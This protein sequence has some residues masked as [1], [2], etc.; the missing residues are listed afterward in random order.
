MSTTVSTVPWKQFW[1][2]II[3]P[4]LVLIASL[5]ADNIA[6][7]NHGSSLFYGFKYILII[8]ALLPF[9]YFGLRENRSLFF[10]L[11]IGFIF[12]LLYDSLHQALSS[13]IADPIPEIE[14]QF[15]RAVSL[16]LYFLLLGVCLIAKATLVKHTQEREV[17]L[18]EVVDSKR[19][20]ENQ[21][22]ELELMG[23]KSGSELKVISGQKE[24]IESINTNLRN[25]LITKNNLLKHTNEE[26]IK[27]AGELRQFSFMV[28][29]NLR[30]PVAALKGLF[31][32]IN[33]RQNGDND[34]ISK[35]GEVL[36]NL[37]NLMY[38][39]NK[40][41]N[42]RNE[43]Y[44]T[45]EKVDLQDELENIKELLHADIDSFDVQID[46]DFSKQEHVYSVKS[47]VNSILFNLVS[48]GIKY[49][50]KGE[51][52]KIQIWTEKTE[53]FTLL[54]VK[55]YGIG[56][57]TVKNK[58]N[59]FR[60]YSRFNHDVEGRGIGLYLCKMQIESLGGRIDIES[61][62]GEWTEFT[63]KFEN[64][65]A[66]NRQVFFENQSAIM[67]HDED[68]GMNTVSWKDDIVFGSYKE[69]YSH[70]VALQ[71]QHLPKKWVIDCSSQ[72]H[73]PAE[74]HLWMQRNIIPSLD[75]SLKEI[76]LILNDNMDEVLREEM[77]TT[78][79]LLEK[80]DVSVNLFENREDFLSQT[81]SRK[82]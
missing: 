29:H 75:I 53:G 70:L 81:T 79:R 76:H 22:R 10:S 36:V 78:K 27:H 33:E 15:V 7:A 80:Q 58:K 25:K 43:V 34:L 24:E 61:E 19:L 6:G 12:I 37:D 56:L 50:S 21:R 40:I 3:I 28:S 35:V 16:P 62:V 63:V 49:H 5:F 14:F 13:G 39:L 44:R 51:Q 42:I 59:L 60:L 23:Q 69:I 77:K 74:F 68:L 26:L 8:V 45:K 1:Q 57:D 11:F 82:Q 65:M 32:L 2:S 30:A 48:N 72:G 38:D 17:L 54:K 18:K 73:I 41:T 66:T 20:I 55:D 47:I 64:S 67:Y 9:H 31:N 46:S 52:A 71:A 4:F